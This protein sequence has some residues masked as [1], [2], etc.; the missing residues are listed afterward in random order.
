MLNYRKTRALPVAIALGSIVLLF[1]LW[2]GGAVESIKTSLMD[3]LT[4][5]EAN[6]TF[7]SVL[8]VLLFGVMVAMLL[9]ASLLTMA[10]GVIFKPTA[11]G[12]LLVLLGSQLGLALAVLLGQTVLRPWVE[13]YKKK[14][15]FMRSLDM[16][17]ARE[18]FKIVLLIRFSPVVPFGIANYMFSVTSISL[19]LLQLATFCGNIP[20]AVAYTVLG[21]YIGSLSG[22]SDGD[23]GGEKGDGEAQAFGP[24]TKALAAL[25]SGIILIWTVVYIGIVARGAL[26]LATMRNPSDLDAA[27]EEE[28]AAVAAAGSLSNIRVARRSGDVESG[29]ASESGP[30]MP[31]E[32]DDNANESDPR[33]RRRVSG[34]ASRLSVDSASSMMI[35]DVDED[36]EGPV[37]LNGY[38]LADRTLL[39]RTFWA[40]AAVLV[41][42]V[43]GIF[44]FV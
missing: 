18:G 21:S 1:I 3:V 28:E 37:D 35:S 20:G 32:R 13:N 40:L 5:I 42:G 22:I 24:K 44:A 15:P 19:P 41:F 2:R 7:G 33:D 36:E 12:V 30:L 4:Y 29:H 16:A 27:I 6:K 43:S 14:S 34:V 25:G 17:L 38:T 26:R 31:S 10:A 8:F 9:P 23:K 39:K 11:L